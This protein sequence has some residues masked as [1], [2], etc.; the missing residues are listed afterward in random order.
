[1]NNERGMDNTYV[2]SIFE[3]S[4]SHIGWSGEWKKKDGIPENK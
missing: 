3:K 2:N 1:M 4:S